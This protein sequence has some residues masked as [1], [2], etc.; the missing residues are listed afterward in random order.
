MEEYKDKL[1]EA[2]KNEIQ[3]ELQKLREMMGDSAVELEPLKK[4]VETV[5]QAA[6]KIGKAM[7]ANQGSQE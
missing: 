5:K 3:S 6:M 4:Q 1:P 7:Y 2:D